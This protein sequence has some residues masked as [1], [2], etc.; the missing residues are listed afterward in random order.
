MSITERRRDT[1]FDKAA[2]LGVKCTRL[3]DWPQR[4]L[5]LSARSACWIPCRI[6]NPP[7][8]DIARGIKVKQ[9]GVGLE[10]YIVNCN[11][12]QHE[13]YKE[14]DKS[15]DD[16]YWSGYRINNSP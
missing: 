4:A 8:R 9:G 14:I 2:G 3:L 16:M 12:I 1:S 15:R 10:Y 11:R 13:I 7:T 6:G 5:D